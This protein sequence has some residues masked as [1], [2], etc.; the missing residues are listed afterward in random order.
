M[1][2]HVKAPPPAT[3][4]LALSTEIA[5]RLAYYSV[6]PDLAV[7]APRGWH[8]INIYG[9]NGAD[10]IVSPRLLTPSAAV[11]VLRSKSLAGPAV[12]LAFSNGFTS[13]R[14][15][16]ATVVSRAFPA[17]K[18]LVDEA[19]DEYDR[20]HP[21]PQTPFA[22]DR[23]HYLSP[24]L[25][26]FETPQGETGLGNLLAPLRSD[27]ALPISGAHI[28]VPDRGDCCDL[29]SV[30]ARLAAADSSLATFITRQAERDAKAP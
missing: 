5:E 11:R 1:S 8:C 17:H 22:T 10:L 29:V 14:D 18:K 27:D 9:S 16:V 30:S 3:K 2:G 24:E 15:E 4:R 13:G 19:A 28:L 26:E 21:A 7:L 23:L 25:V 12:V 20:P 6:Q